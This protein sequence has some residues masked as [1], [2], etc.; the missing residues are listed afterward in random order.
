MFCLNTCLRLVYSQLQPY[1]VIPYLENT[2]L[3]H[4]C[5][6]QHG[7]QTV[8]S[9]TEKTHPLY[10]EEPTWEVMPESSSTLGTAPK[11]GGQYGTC[12]EDLNNPYLESPSVTG[13]ILQLHLMSST[14]CHQ[15]TQG[16]STLLHTPQL[17]PH[18]LSFPPSVEQF[19]LGIEN[20]ML[21]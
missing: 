8:H 15:Y 21:W 7:T 18:N 3:Q 1:L 13:C 2:Q 14:H 11:M 17:Y 19:H 6:S 4:S 20:T 9:W 12:V 10:S 5:S 16:P